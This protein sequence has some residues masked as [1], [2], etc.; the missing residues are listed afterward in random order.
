MDMNTAKVTLNVLKYRLHSNPT[1]MY[2]VPCGY[3]SW[4][5]FVWSEMSAMARQNGF[6]LA[7]MGHRRLG[8]LDGPLQMR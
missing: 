8:V 2:G 3:G 6:G 1:S 5:Q 4:K 7:D